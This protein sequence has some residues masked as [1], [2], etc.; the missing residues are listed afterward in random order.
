MLDPTSDEMD[1]DEGRL[2]LAMMPYPN[3][4]SVLFCRICMLVRWTVYVS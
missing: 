3:E 2:L 1:A 4:V